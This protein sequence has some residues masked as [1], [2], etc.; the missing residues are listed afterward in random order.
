[1]PRGDRRIR[2]VWASL[3]AAAAFLAWA[4]AA[5]S[6]SPERRNANPQTNPPNGASTPATQPTTINQIFGTANNAEPPRT[7]QHGDFYRALQKAQT[8]PIV[9]VTVVIAI[10]AGWQ[11][12]V[13]C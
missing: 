12:A 10:F 4:A 1:M 5:T 7:E 11:V 8:D 6:Q 9:W 2:S 13:Y 3:T